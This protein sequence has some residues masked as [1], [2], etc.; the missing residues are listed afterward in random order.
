M[1]ESGNTAVRG[2]GSALTICEEGGSVP[3]EPRS[4][5]GDDNEKRRPGNTPP[6]KIRLKGIIV[7][8]VLPVESLLRIPIVYT[9]S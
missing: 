7:D 2:E 6:C 1:D 3:L 8:E 5:T 4:Y 9:I